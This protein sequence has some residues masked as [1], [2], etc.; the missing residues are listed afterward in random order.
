MEEVEYLGYELM[1]KGIKP[2]PKKVLAI[3]AIE[4]PTSVKQLCRFLGMV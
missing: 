4:P 1:Y 2:M 3:L